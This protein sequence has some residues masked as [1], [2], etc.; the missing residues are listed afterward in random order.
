MW[1]GFIYVFD[2]AC[3]DH[4]ALLGLMHMSCWFQT[5]H[6]VGAGKWLAILTTAL[7]ANGVGG[8]MSHRCHRGDVAH[9]QEDACPTH[10]PRPALTRPSPSPMHDAPLAPTH[11]PSPTSTGPAQWVASPVACDHHCPYHL[12]TI[13]LTCYPTSS[14]AL[15]PITCH[16]PIMRH[17]ATTAALYAP[18]LP[19]YMPASPPHVSPCYPSCIYH[20]THLRSS[21]CLRR[22]HAILARLSG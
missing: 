19:P 5:Q 15:C 20:H 4:L 11:M 21:T 17:P 22:A 7:A 13:T 3:M 18:L 6:G 1:T 8:N 10:D 14:L 9:R 16:H 2:C 12:T